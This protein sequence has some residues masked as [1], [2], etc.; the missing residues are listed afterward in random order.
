MKKKVIG[1]IIAI[2]II[3]VGLFQAIPALADTTGPLSYVTILQ[4]NQE[5]APGSQL[6]FTA[7]A[8]DNNDVAISGANY[9]WML[10][11]GGGTIT[12][13]GLF[14]AGTTP[15]TFDN[16]IEVVA[17]KGS[18]SATNITSVT[19][20]TPG[21]LTHVT[22]T[23][24]SATVQINGSQ[25]F[26]AQGY[27]ANNVA[28][29]GLTYNW[30]VVNGGSI[31]SGL[32]HAPGTTGT[33]TVTVT[34]DDTAISS[35]ATVSVV[36]SV[37]V[38]NHI[39]IT[40]S[41]ATVKAGDTKQFTAQGYDIN[42]VALTGLTYEWAVVNGGGSIDSTGLLTAG[43][44]AGKYT[45]TVRTTGT[46][47]TVNAYATVSVTPNL[48]AVNSTVNINKLMSMFKGMMNNA[49]FSSFL[50]GQ[51]QVKNGT[52]I[53]TV[54]LIPGTVNTFTNGILTIDQNTGGSA[55]FTIMD[56]TVIQPKNT[57]LTNGD[58][59]VVVTVNDQVQLVVKIT[60]PNMGQMQMPPGL[61]KHPDNR[62]GKNVPPGW[63]HGKKAG[64][65]SR[66]LDNND[67]D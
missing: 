25:Q 14:T 6:Q 55:S 27:D 19:I 46:G 35:S 4:A 44:T 67:D 36:Q 29:P 12:T 54:K 33:S 30:S 37:G 57:T 11:N 13:A 21:P 61:R 53:D 51:W 16:T 64:W 65:G 28:I 41:K 66:P 5:V 26:N 2:A 8:Y 9:F 18:Y 50:G 45:N 56:N 34:V 42:N 20:G 58:K 15:G 38:L 49:N 22:I 63:D 1:I 39:V 43:S 40:P 47:T 31:D 17:V 62:D 52:T 32:F 23:P 10:N 7:Q 24:A 48:S 60:A 3:G 59:V